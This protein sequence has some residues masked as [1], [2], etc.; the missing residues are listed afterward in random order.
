MFNLGL[1]SYRFRV[2]GY[3]E[4]KLTA[5]TTESSYAVLQELGGRS[6]VCWQWHNLWD[7]KACFQWHAS[8]NTA[9]SPNLSQAVLPS[10]NQVFK[11][12]SLWG[13]FSF[14]PP[15]P[16]S[17]SGLNH[18]DIWWFPKPPWL[19]HLLPSPDSWV[20]MYFKFL[21]LKVSHTS[22]TVLSSKCSTLQSHKQY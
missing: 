22:D 13:P 3:G 16:E 15:N 2:H 4:K 9:T 19:A 5:E 20:H 8:S 21:L 6:G 17:S 11:H 14:K 7:L 1:K 18:V 12:L 10:G